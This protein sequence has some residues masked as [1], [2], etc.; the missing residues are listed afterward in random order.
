[1]KYSA[2]V[3]R[4]VR[5][6]KQLTT[7]TEAMQR[8]NILAVRD[9]IDFRYA[10]SKYRQEMEKIL[11][12]IGV[13]Q[14]ESL[15]DFQLYGSQTLER[16]TLRELGLLTKSGTFLLAGR[17]II[18]IRD[19]KGEVTA[20]V[21]WYPDIKKYITTPTVGYSTTHQLFNIEIYKATMTRETPEIPRG[22]VVL[23][24]GIFDALSLRAIGIPAVATMGLELGRVKAEMLQRFD[25]VY[26]IHDRDTAG[27]KTDKYASTVDAKLVWKIPNEVASIRLP[28]P[29]KDVDEYIHNA[30][31]AKEKLYKAL[32]SKAK[33][34]I[35]L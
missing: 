22:L 34:L 20:W 4:I 2:E 6:R 11:Q 18:P 5:V 19:I 14:I 8:L 25:S 30:E 31:G 1:M 3:T 23:V 16:S 21:G 29:Y 24:E 7:L 12:E 32:N 9:I 13:L 10:H 35:C 27:A 15:I 28:Y 17:N 33:Y 26:S